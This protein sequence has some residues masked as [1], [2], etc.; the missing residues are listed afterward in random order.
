[1]SDEQDKQS[2]ATATATK[3]PAAKRSAA[4][5]A[6]PAATSTAPTRG[7]GPT[8]PSDEPQRT[9]AGEGPAPDETATPAQAPDV[10]VSPGTTTT[11]KDVATQREEQLEAG[12][13]TGKAK[14]AAAKLAA[15]SPVEQ[16]AGR[17][18]AKLNDGRVDNMSR[19]SDADAL[20]G[21][22]VQID[23]NDDEHGK[24]AVKA[25]EAVLG[26]GNAGLG[27]GD[28]GVFVDVGTRD[29]DG[30]PLTTTVMTRDEHGA[31]IPGI[32]YGALRPIDGGGR[33]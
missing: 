31:Q 5:K 22:F 33:R 2:G 11:H 17:L 32:P 25:A 24:E 18:G 23:Y 12:K 20:F 13:V 10:P 16:R 3:K 19:R 4:R 29:E 15:A 1:M 9:S 27:R 21:H 8:A 30:Y 26:E 14:T 6:K 28:Y 7:S